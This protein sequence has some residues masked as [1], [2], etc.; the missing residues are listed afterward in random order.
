VIGWQWSQTISPLSLKLASG[1]IH[2]A[3]KSIV[4]V[5]QWASDLVPADISRK[6]LQS[7]PVR[8]RWKSY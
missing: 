4:E 2:G 6:A 7:L 1:R 3:G 5:G 8:E